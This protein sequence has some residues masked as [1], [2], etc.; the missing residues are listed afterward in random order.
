MTFST[1][2]ARLRILSLAF[3]RGEVSAKD[4]FEELGEELGAGSIGTV[5]Y[6]LR[7]LCREM[8]LK[9]SRTVRVRGATQRFY[10]PTPAAARYLWGLKAVLD[11]E[12]A[13]ALRALEGERDA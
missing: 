10:K 6:H 5:A 13:D 1:E 3:R 2:V 12:V 4:V 8:V 7:V 9:Q 11:T